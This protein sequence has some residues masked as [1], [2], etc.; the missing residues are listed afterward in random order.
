[1]SFELLPHQ[2]EAINKLSNGKILYGGVGT[3][4]TFTALSYYLKS[5]SHRDVVVITT[6]KVRD[7]LDW[8]DSAAQLN[9]G[10]ERFTVDSWNKIGNYVDSE[11]KFFIFDEQRLVGSGAW[12]KAFLKIAKK[13]NWIILSGTP[14]DVWMDYAA[15]FIANGFYKNF[16]DFKRQHVQYAPNRTFP[17]IIGYFRQDIL[18]RHRNHVLVEMPFEKHTTQHV[19]WIECEHDSEEYRRAIRTRWNPFTDEPMADVSELARVLR[20]LVNSDDS[21]LTEIKK[22][23]KMHPRLIIFYTFN[24]ELELLRELD[25]LTNVYEWN[26]HRKDTLPT[27]TDDEWVYLV[28]YT[29]G[30][31]G[32]NCITTNAMVFYSMTYSYKA[33]D[34]AMGRIDRLNTGFSDLYYYVLMSSSLIDKTIK[35]ALDDKKDF[36]ERIF[37]TKHL[38]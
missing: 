8:V 2:E 26:G 11:G 17:S 14:G 19:N 27:G 25:K 20:R 32:W 6:P 35:K 21:R 12:V 31:E 30:A 33:F 7:S 24:Y 34:Q 10:P 16:T 15:V 22:F 4:K 23:M 9:I 5:Q 28:Q 3:G 1:M 13:N 36:N 38:M 37:A 29:S 18:E